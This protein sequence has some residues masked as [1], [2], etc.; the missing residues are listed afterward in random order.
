MRNANTWNCPH[1]TRGNRMMRRAALAYDDCSSLTTLMAFFDETN[2]KSAVLPS[3]FSIDSFASV[4]QQKP[5]RPLSRRVTIITIIVI[6][7]A[8]SAE[9]KTR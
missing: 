6:I 9:K 4:G 2:G 8:S 3:R 5:E 7:S 1:V